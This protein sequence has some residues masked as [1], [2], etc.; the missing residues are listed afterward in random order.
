MENRDYRL[1][2]I[3]AVLAALG[4]LARIISAFVGHPHSTDTLPPLAI[5]QPGPKSEQDKIDEQSRRAV[6]QSL[7]EIRRQS[8]MDPSEPDS[9]K[10]H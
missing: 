1:H 3:T 8:G 5:A 7:A 10:H 2:K 4:A 6:F 9:V